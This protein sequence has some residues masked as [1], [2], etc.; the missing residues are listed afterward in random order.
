MLGLVHTAP[1]LCNN[2]EK[3]L[4]FCESV[5]TDPQEN[6]AKTEVFEN[7]IESGYTHENGVF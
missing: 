4:C 3:N 7:A 2:G 1:R 6:A 5:H